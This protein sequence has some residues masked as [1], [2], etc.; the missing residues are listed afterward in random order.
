MSVGLCK[1]YEKSL[2][3]LIR[4][5]SSQSCVWVYLSVSQSVR[6]LPPT[7]SD[8]WFTINEKNEIKHQRGK[9]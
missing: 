8:Q 7:G 3:Y 1:K 2:N 5:C 9:N 4:Y 6:K